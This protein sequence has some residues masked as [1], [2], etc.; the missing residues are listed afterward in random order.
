MATR[1]SMWDMM[2]MGVRRMGRDE[3][4]VEFMLR[5]LMS[6][7]MNITIGMFMT[8]VTF[9]FSLYSIIV[10]YQ[11][12]ILSGTVFFTAAAL[13]AVSFAVSW[14][15]AIYLGTAGAVYVGAK[16]IAANMRLEGGRAGG[17]SIRR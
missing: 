17:G 14:L 1:S 2:F 15:I 12:D 11:A 6:I 4:M 3:N 16:A 10:A 9:V 5:A 8:V 13:A 7:L